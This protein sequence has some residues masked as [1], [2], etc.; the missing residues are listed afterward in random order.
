MP[1][2]NH[3]SIR[4]TRHLNQI[5]RSIRNVNQLITRETDPHRLLDQSCELLIE[6]RGFYNAWIVLIKDGKPQE[7]F[8]HK[9]FSSKFSDMTDALKEGCLPDCI[10]EAARS[11]TAVSIDH[12]ETTC[13]N[14][15]LS[16][17]Y[18][19]R[20]GITAP[21][22]HDDHTFGFLT[23]SVPREFAEDPEEK[24][25]LLEIAGDIGFAL[26]DL[27]VEAERIRLEK[28]LRLNE[29][30]LRL[31]L[32]SIGDG[33][34][35][36][37][38]QG[39]VQDMNCVARELTGW[40]LDDAR[41]KPMEEVFHIV[42]A[43]TGEK[44]VNPIR[45][46]LETGRIQG[47]ANHTK[48]ISRD[49]TEY[50]I[51][52]SAAP[53]QDPEKMICGVVMVFRDVTEEYN[54][55]QQLSD[56]EQ[57]LSAIYEN[58]PHVIL[59]VDTDRRV[60]KINRS[61]LTLSGRNETETLG[62]RGGEALRCLHHLDD[63]EGC[64]FGPKCEECRIKNTVLDTLKT[65]QSHINVEAEYVT[66]TAE[67][68]TELQVRISTSLVTVNDESRVLVTIQDITQAK[69][70]KQELRETRERLDL[71]LRGG[72]LGT[73]DW[74]IPSGRVIFNDQWAKM[75]G[76]RLDELDPHL[77]TWKKL[78]HPEDLP[79]TEKTLSAHLE[80]KTPAY[81]A[82]FRMKHRDG[83]W[84]WILD[85]GVV[86]ERDPKGNP[87]RAC[88][89]H[90]EVTT[91][92]RLQTELETATRILNQA[93]EIAQVGSYTWDIPSDKLEWSD[94]MYR[95]AGLNPKTFYG[96]LSETIQKMIH[97]DDRGPVG[98][99]IADML[100]QG[101]TWPFEFR[102]IRPDG[103]IRWLRSTSRFEF[104]ENN[105]PVICFGVHHDITKAREHQEQLR[106]QADILNSIDDRVTVTDLEGRITYVNDAVCHMMQKD[107]GEIIGK[108]TH[109]FGENAAKGATQDQI[110]K[111]TIEKGG[112]RGEI[113]N[114]D[115]NGHEIILECRTKAIK[116]TH[117][118]T[119]ALCGISTDITDR[120]RFEL[121]LKENETRYRELFNNMANGVAV[122]EV[123]ENGTDFI[124]K[125]FNK[126]AER[127]TSA[128][129][130]DV[131]GKSIFQTFPD[132]EQTGMIDFFRRVWKTGKPKGFPV[133]RYDN[134]QLIAWYDNYVYKLPSNE[135]V[136]VFNDV[137]DHKRAI[138]ALRASEEKNRKYIENAP[139]G[140][141][142]VDKNGQYV[143]VNAAACSMT[144]YSR[145]EL[146]SM[147]IT[148]LA[149]PEDL[150]QARTGF[151]QL[152][153]T[154]KM[155]AEL[156]LRKKDGTVFFVSLKAVQLE[157]NRFIA[158]CHDI[159]ERKLARQ[160]LKES[161][162][163]Y[164]SLI[165]NL[166]VG[167]Y[168]NTGGPK[169]IFLEANKAIAEMFGYDTVDEFK[170]IHVSDLYQDPHD[171]KRFVDK[172]TRQ[173]YARNEEIRL[174]KK[175]GTPMWAAVT[176]SLHFDSDGNVEWMDGVIEDISERK[177]IENKLKENELR[178][179]TL[180]EA[181]T[182]A[183]L[184][185]DKQTLSIIDA[186]PAAEK[187]YGYTRKNF[188]GMKVPDISAEPD[189]TRDSVKG[190]DMFVPLR[191]HRKK[192]G[193]VFPV[194]VSDSSF[195]LSGRELKIGTIRDITDKQKMEEDQARTN[196]LESVGL[197]AGGIAHDFNNILQSI[198]GN[199]QLAQIKE[200]S[201]PYL[202]RM[203]HSVERAGQLSEQL[204]TFAKGGSPVRETASV[205]K[206]VRETADFCLGRSTNIRFECTADADLLSG[207]VDSG[208]ISQVIQNLIENARQA[209]PKG[210]TI[211]VDL[212]NH[213]L[214]PKNL[215]E[216]APGNY[217]RITFR[218]TGMGI[219][220]DH[221]ENIFDPYFSTKKTGSGL[222]L[223]TSFSIIN[224]H[225]G[226]ISVA[227]TVGKE[228]GTTFTILLP[229]AEEPEDSDDP[230]K[231]EPSIIRGKGRILLM[232][233]EDDIR[234]TA[235]ELLTTA[236]YHVT[237][238]S[239]GR[240]AVDEYE[241]AMKAGSPYKVVM[242]D[243]TVPEGMSGQEAI[244]QL[245]EID[246]DV[247]AIVCSGYSSDPVVA[248]FKKY[249]FSASASKPYR[250]GHLSEIL[251]RLMHPGEKSKE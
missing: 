161:E 90:L 199:L 14:C 206:I 115:K 154:A 187:L 165:N 133:K 176:A 109:E 39:R 139:E 121:K 44:A 151:E 167:V 192:D 63:P 51:A 138:Q 118:K 237:A 88:G 41:G 45:R 10:R 179:R 181:E 52:D 79:N 40:P 214:E 105:R 81:E 137:T 43:Q 15:P 33:V 13:P 233:D 218:D 2:H 24:E 155:E 48:L 28:E 195:R 23:V 226:H 29:E 123:V 21:I 36:T 104:D 175:N 34:I 42:N 3:T 191:Y 241:R 54:H 225:G 130:Q 189:Q 60:R 234:E 200:D 248:E 205:E 251:D 182:D 164:R 22:R 38:I 49:G 25:L 129:R 230:A 86:M 76:Y 62:L 127:I 203:E 94:H 80:G 231:K 19:G 143:D 128:R 93:Q 174:K 97:P 172:V 64:G 59:L 102:L 180:F 171:R 177:R 185:V 65:G 186:N 215:M 163:R 85:K 166:D 220:E 141:F 37:D 95:I 227:S 239:D 112:F 183:I 87:I 140:V 160:A 169:G 147:S 244:Q 249:G 67:N 228:S 6:T 27:D 116:D 196:K 152:H 246:P 78:V 77:N 18:Q 96:N 153:K 111:Q 148:D 235:S 136:A 101:R 117:G 122:Y 232:D 222:G 73:W 134:N 107:R 204:L 190:K 31:T 113:V 224:K 236:G 242:L 217:I 53:I 243:L 240:R 194:E 74:H 159:T 208:Q 173:G 168:R 125:D 193:T 32:Q 207:N 12:P 219:P 250:L 245:K 99:Q 57:E 1:E 83:R 216:L 71:A 50:Q 145:K 56:R 108:T 202:A 92:K 221:L 70:S 7:P 20:G 4:Q 100:K 103:E 212:K 229:A 72:E 84:I 58:S 120:K 69:K 209:M 9:G 132:A 47:L 30:Q 91:Q 157:P 75:I 146:L 66:G 135:L 119:A 17:H 114:Y 178:Y 61:G 82:E 156:Q 106:S 35:V 8:Y 98:A 201:K 150:S 197:L 184:V 188:L 144:G 26:H 210:G 158:F 223:A 131:I 16:A 5:L 211:S 55:K 124:F 213:M 247:K 68:A 162:E 142:V 149:S 126:E 198:S 110:L 89:T 46:A 238:V 11:A 170:Q